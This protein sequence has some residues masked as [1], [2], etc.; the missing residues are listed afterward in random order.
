MKIRFC[1]IEKW[2]LGHKF[3]V[4]QLSA[5]LTAL[6][7]IQAG[8][9]PYLAPLLSPQTFAK[10]CAGLGIAIIVVRFIKQ[11]IDGDGGES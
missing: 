11:Q 4:V 1:L 3:W 7:A 9:V 8:V 2:K 10:V 5:L 6:S